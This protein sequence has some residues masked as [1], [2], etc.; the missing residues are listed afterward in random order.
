MYQTTPAAPTWNFTS[1]HA[2]CVLERI[3][4]LEETLQVVQHTVRSFE[5]AFGAGWDMSQSLDYFR[6]IVPAVGAFRATVTRADGMFKLSQEQP[7]EVF[8]RVRC[9]FAGHESNR[10]RE[11]ARL[12]AKL[13]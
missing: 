4:S 6:R 10:H 5:S 11:T 9:E 1:V 13:P 7:P 3:E 8:D 2:Q 12:M